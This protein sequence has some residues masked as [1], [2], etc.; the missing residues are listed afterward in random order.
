MKSC[1][2]SPSFLAETAAKTTGE[3]FLNLVE[4]VRNKLANENGKFGTLMISGRLVQ[5]QPIGE[6]IIVGDL[7]G[8]LKSLVHILKD[9]NFLERAK[10]NNTV[11]L[12]FL[13]DYGDRGIKSPEVYFVVLKLKQMFP[14]QIILMRGNHEGPPD[15]RVSPHHLPI[16]LKNKFDKSGSKAY[17]SLQELF[18]HLYTSVIIQER[19]VLLH[20]GVPS[21]A[22]TIDDIAYAHVKHPKKPHLEEILWSDPWS[23]I[24]GTIA[25]PRGAGRLFS[26]SVTEKFLMMLGVKALIRGHQPC[27]NGYEI[28]HNG[29]LLTI[30][31]RKGMP[32]NNKYGAYLDLDLSQEIKTVEELKKSVHKF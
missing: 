19:Y 14:K 5:L 32:Y 28:N 30:F 23:L 11:K 13:G 12:I 8:D 6:I 27:V 24:N 10:H 17:L 25:S 31:S 20:G 21:Q 2:S 15:L 7:H 9:S 4:Q 29:T 18:K 16:Q 1:F 3:E 22:K 26:K